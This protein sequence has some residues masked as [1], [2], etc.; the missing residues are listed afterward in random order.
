MLIAYVDESYNRD[1]YFIGAAIGDEPA[2]ERVSESYDQIHERTGAQHE[3]PTDAEFHGHEIMGGTGDWA[4][5]RGKHREAAGLYSAVLRASHDAGIRYI[6]R[7]VDVGRL[8]ARYS[9]PRPPHAVVL[10]HLLERIEDLTVADGG[11]QKS[12]VVADQISTHAEHQAQFGIYQQMGTDG[13]RPSRLEH[14]SSPINFAD[15]RLTPGLQAVDMAVYVH[16]RAE[17][18]KVQH[19]RAQIVTDRLAKLIY[20]STSHR[21]LWLP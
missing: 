9:Y 1:Y 7:G 12:I 5:F 15:S 18:V 17:T 21:H 4:A 13:Y 10:G 3:V 6:F 19:P 14:I 2:W 8:N 16:R 11:T 20:A